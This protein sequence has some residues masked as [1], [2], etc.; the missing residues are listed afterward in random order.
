MS[1]GE[2]HVYCGASTCPHT[3]KRRQHCNH[4]L[5]CNLLVTLLL[6][7]S[8][9]SQVVAQELHDERRVLV[10]VLSDVVKLCGGL[11]IGET[12]IL[13]GLALCVTAAELSDVTVVVGLHLLVEDLRLSRG[14]LR[15]QI[16]IQQ[17]EDGVTNLLE[18]A[19]HLEA[20]LLRKRGLLLVA[21]GLLLVLDTGDDAPCSTTAAHCVLVSN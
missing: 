9:Q 3:T 6:V 16:A 21:L 4:E 20:I 8:P 10:R 19:P 5:L 2:L 11:L 7:R 15:D 17:A 18:L 1:V 13:R 14:G 12:C